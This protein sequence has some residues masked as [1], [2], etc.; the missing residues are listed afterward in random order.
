MLTTRAAELPPGASR[1][2]PHRLTLAR[3]GG[4]VAADERAAL[5]AELTR[6]A[7]G[8]RSACEPLFA[9]LWPL[10]RGVASRHLEAADAEDAAQRALIA[11]F[12]RAAQFDPERDAVAWAVGLA[13]WEI[14][15]LRRQRWRR[16]DATGE[17][18]LDD[19]AAAAVSPEEAAIAADL[20]AAL[21]RTLHAL[22]PADVEVLLRDA[23]DERLLGAGFRKRLQRARERLRA[24][25]RERHG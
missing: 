6:L 22:A 4:A 9:R 3:G 1:P 11:L 18:E 19:R 13:L 16:R 20:Y 17:T 12:A 5:Q 8:D 2:A 14:R 7:D 24:A 21:G 25:W 10:L 15:S 23:R